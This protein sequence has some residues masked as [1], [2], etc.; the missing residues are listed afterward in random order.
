LFEA[1]FFLF[2]EIQLASTR[3]LATLASMDEPLQSTRDDLA[4][5]HEQFRVLKHDI[6]NSIAVL[7]ALAELSQQNP[8]HYEKLANI[9]L[10]RCPEMVNKL[11][12]YQKRIEEKLNAEKP[13]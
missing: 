2:V 1:A 10:T 13:A 4:S 11:L 12:T 7:M 8:V 5:L 3:G 9:I 6:N